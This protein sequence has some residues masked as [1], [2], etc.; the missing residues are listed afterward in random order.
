MLACCC[1]QQGDRIFAP[2][3]AEALSGLPF[4]LQNRIFQAAKEL[5]E[6]DIEAAA[7]N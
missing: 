6:P 3:D 2:N 4:S 1:D 5:N 7:K